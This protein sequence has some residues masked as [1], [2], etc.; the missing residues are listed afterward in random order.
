MYGVWMPI[1]PRGSGSNYIA[2]W[3]LFRYGRAT[4]I[5]SQQSVAAAP[6]NREAR[7]AAKQPLRYPPVE[8]N[9]SQA[10]AVAAGFR[11]A[12]DD[13]GYKVHA[14]AILPDHVH[15]VI[16]MHRRK[17]R[18]IVGHMRSRATRELKDRNE[19]FADER[20]VWGDHGWNV[21]L[22]T[23][24]EVLRAIRYVEENPLKEGKKRQRWSFVTPFELHTAILAAQAVEREGLLGRR[25]GGAAVRSRDESARRKRRG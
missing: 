13:A 6:H 18:L 8:I 3:E 10:V 17:I 22:Y 5:T 4:K 19:W 7:L 24:Q 15:M 21:F 12:C 20:R 11:I 2:K 14:C 23:E 1:D 25:I 9:G 16:G